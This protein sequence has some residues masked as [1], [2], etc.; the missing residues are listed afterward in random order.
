[1]IRR[2]P[3]RHKVV[4]AGLLADEH[5]TTTKFDALYKEPHDDGQVG[6]RVC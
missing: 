2:L 3:E 6:G 5:Q 1:M 4:V